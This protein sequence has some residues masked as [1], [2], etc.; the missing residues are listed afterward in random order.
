MFLVMQRKP[1]Y[2]GRGETIHDAI[3]A[4]MYIDKGDAV[5]VYEG[6][7]EMYVDG[8]GY[9]YNGV[10]DPPKHVGNGVVTRSSGRKVYAKFDV[11]YDLESHDEV[12]G[13]AESPKT[14]FQQIAKAAVPPEAVTKEHAEAMIQNFR[15]NHPEI[16]AY[17]TP[18]ID[19]MLK[20]IDEAERPAP[21]GAK[22]KRAAALAAF[23]STNK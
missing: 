17:S 18:G 14:N 23:L 5:A 6:V 20:E 8:V 16:A 19:T 1:G 12:Q 22:A 4:A 3:V 9:V 7:G 15:A 10:K 21:K 13:H 11:R 2:W